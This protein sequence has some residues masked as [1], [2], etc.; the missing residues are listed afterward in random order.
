MRWWML[1]VAAGCAAA[2]DPEAPVVDDA[3]EEPPACAEGLDE[4]QCAPD[5]ALRDADGVEVRLSGHRGRPV[6]VVGSSMW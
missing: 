6:L 5:F 3:V 4:G 1:G 2:R